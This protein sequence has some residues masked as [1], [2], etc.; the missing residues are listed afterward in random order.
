[1]CA[2]TATMFTSLH[3]SR[4]KKAK[5]VMAPAWVVFTLFFLSVVCTQQLK[6]NVWAVYSL[7]ERV[8]PGSSDHFNLALV[9]SCPG[10]QRACFVMS[11]D[12]DGKIKIVGTSASELTAAIGIYFRQYCNMTI[13]WPRG[14]GSNIFWPSSWPKVGTSTLKQR[15]V[16]WNYIMNVCPWSFYSN[17]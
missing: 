15:V 3:Y 1:L 9:D 8:L 14:G 2:R 10:T 7:L 5:L 17:L 11:D 4:H 12:T 6:G 16:P 13:G